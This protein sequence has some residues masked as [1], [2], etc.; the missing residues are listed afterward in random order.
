VILQSPNDLAVIV[1]HPENSLGLGQ[2]DF[3]RGVDFAYIFVTILLHHLD[4][5]LV[6]GLGLA[7]GIIRAMEILAVLVVE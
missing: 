7:Q 4:L 6:Q 5:I 2:L 3:L 1:L